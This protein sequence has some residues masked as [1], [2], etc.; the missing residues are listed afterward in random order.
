MASLLKLPKL[1]VD[2]IA[3]ACPYDVILTGN[4][5]ELAEPTTLHPETTASVLMRGECLPC[6]Q[7]PGILRS[8]SLT[9]VHADRDKILNSRVSMLA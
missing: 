1:L 8:P 5:E 9:T 6:R 3:L 7:P 4:D 2:N